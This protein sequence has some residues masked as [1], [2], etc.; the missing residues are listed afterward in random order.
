MQHFC[1]KQL[2]EFILFCGCSVFT[3]AMFCLSKNGERNWLRPFCKTDGR[4]WHFG[5]RVTDDQTIFQYNLKTEHS[6]KV[7]SP[8]PLRKTQ[9]QNQRLNPCWYTIHFKHVAYLWQHIS[10]K[11]KSLDNW[12]LHHD[13]APKNKYQCWKNCCT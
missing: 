4:T 5:K 1:I 11:T 7:Q 10:R 13:N 8:R 6:W 3:C 12:I 9:C 2:L